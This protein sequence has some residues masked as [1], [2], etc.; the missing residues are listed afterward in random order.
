MINKKVLIIAPYLNFSSESGFN[1]FLYIAQ[2]LS[3]KNEVTL[4]T[5]NF[6]HVKKEKRDINKIRLENPSFN[7]FFVN[8]FGYDSNFSLSRL[9]SILI[10][11]TNL[12]KWLFMNKNLIKG[13]V[14]YTGYPLIL[15]NLFL[16]NFFHKF[17]R[18]LYID[19]QDIW[20]HSISSIIGNNL[21]FVR[22]L[23]V[24]K[25]F[26]FSSLK[27]VDCFFSVSESYSN[28]FKKYVPKVPVEVIYIGADFSYVNSLP[29]VY[30]DKIGQ[31]NFFYFG[32]L[33]YSY[34][35]ECAINTF[36][37]LAAE[38]ETFFF[39]VFGNGPD[40]VRLKSISSEN[41]IFY[42]NV[43][44]DRMISMAK[45]MDIA[46]NLISKGSPQSITNKLSDYFAL[47]KPIISSSGNNEV[48]CL[49]EEV[50]GYL[51]SSGD[52]FSLLEKIRIA[53]SNIK[54]N[55]PENHNFNKSITKFDRNVSY[56][57]IFTRISNYS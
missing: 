13:S 23:N 48:E 37:L 10:C 39:H 38:K 14:V 3:Q 25:K 1:R 53:V 57:K 21:F 27:N 47:G 15:F 19:V 24:I 54:R 45:G 4:L 30:P 28:Y 12:I 50:N 9:Y 16:S 7:I 35:I 51:Y 6:S 41:I 32:T 52:T 29:I 33:S 42:G 49:I 8:E 44:Y 2:V 40:L 43:P 20:P 46:L 55:C 31:Y 22:C 34:D 18:S 26:I 56:R 36:K 5:S 17:Y 11:E